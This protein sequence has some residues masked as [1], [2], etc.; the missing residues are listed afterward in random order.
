M[1][2]SNQVNQL[3]SCISPP[4]LSDDDL[5]DALDGHASEWVKSHLEVCVFCSANLKQMAKLETSLKQNMYRTDCLSSD[6]VTDYA[7]NYH[8][9]ASDKRRIE[10]HIS[11]CRLCEQ[12]VQTLRTL[13]VSEEE[14]VQSDALV[15]PLWEQ[16]KNFVRSFEQFSQVLLPQSVP[17]YGQLKGSSGLPNRILTYG[18]K[19]V[20]VMLSLE[21]VKD[22]LKVNGVIL[23]SEVENLWRQARAELVSIKERRG[24][25]VAIDDEET[26]TFA[27]VK[28]GH[29]DLN[30]YMTS[31]QTLRIQDIDIQL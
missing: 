9:T 27:S 22:G 30:I 4:P 21:K 7:M 20:S 12:E 3:A 11:Q 28:A 29:Y 8:L 19:Q 25:S 26:F 23:D 16:A 2:T 6:E 13:F 24:E 14:Q 18:N 31:G 1:K 5:L 15:T 10:Y 17:A